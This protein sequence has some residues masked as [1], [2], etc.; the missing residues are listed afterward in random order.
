MGRNNGDIAWLRVGIVERDVL[1]DREL[2]N[3]LVSIGR[4]RNI[5]SCMVAVDDVLDFKKVGGHHERAKENNRICE[6]Y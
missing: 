5:L 1:V 4:C 2:G 3:V 6:I